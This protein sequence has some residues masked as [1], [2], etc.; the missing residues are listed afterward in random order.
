[1]ENKKRKTPLL[2]LKNKI[3][4]TI[5]EKIHE[6]LRLKGKRRIEHINEFFV[7]LERGST[8]SVQT[9][10]SFSDIRGIYLRH[11]YDP[12]KNIGI[13]VYEDEEGQVHPI[14]FENIESIH[15]N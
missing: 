15:E 2:Q 9:L 1:M 4:Q 13:L 8:I 7:N 11:I 6:L 12:E 5:F 14:S 10:N 3:L